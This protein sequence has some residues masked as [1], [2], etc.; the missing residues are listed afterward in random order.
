[1]AKKIERSRIDAGRFE[2]P[3]KLAFLS[4]EKLD[5]A[6]VT[7]KDGQWSVEMPAAA[8]QKLAKSRAEL[9]LSKT[10]QKRLQAEHTAALEAERA[11]HQAT[12]D[13][14]VKL[15]RRLKTLEK[16]LGAGAE[17]PVA[18]RKKATAV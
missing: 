3:T 17:A 6:S 4:A 10:E 1:M 12:R 18:V 9:K 8:L 14:L 16:K 2:L 15:Q 5:F 7:D 11:A 13:E